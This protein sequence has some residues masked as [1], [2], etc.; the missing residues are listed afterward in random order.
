MKDTEGEPLFSPLNL[1]FHSLLSFSKDFSLSHFNSMFLLVQVGKAS[2]CTTTR[3]H[4]GREELY[5]L[6]TTYTRVILK[7]GSIVMNVTSE[8]VG[9]VC[10]YSNERKS[11]GTRDVEK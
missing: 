3:I 11:Y 10:Y 7:V 1:N 4:L 8:T 2:V 5:T 6:C 9:D